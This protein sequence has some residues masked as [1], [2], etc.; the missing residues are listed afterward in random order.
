[1]FIYSV[2]GQSIKLV[3]SIIASVLAIVLVF[4]FIPPD[5]IITSSEDLEVG[6]S[7]DQKNFKNIESNEDRINFLKKYGWEVDGQARK[8]EEITIPIHFDPI[9]EKYNQLQIGEGLDLEKYK[10]KSV[11]KYTY[12]VNNYEYDGIVLANLLIYEEKVIGGDIC[13]ASI[14]GFLHGFTKGNNFLT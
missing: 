6:K 10:G 8:V 2:K 12:L 3:F 9:Y 13:S 14:D 5:K 7:V 11:K 1:M 4:I